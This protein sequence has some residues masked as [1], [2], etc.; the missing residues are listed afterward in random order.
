M[1]LFSDTVWHS[2]R[3][4]LLSAESSIERPGSVFCYIMSE[5]RLLRRFYAHVSRASL[6]GDEWFEMR[7][8]STSSRIFSR[9]GEVFG[10]RKVMPGTNLPHVVI[11]FPFSIS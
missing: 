8:S 5:L 9:P 4:T 3:A 10:D 7:S 6:T 11:G 2:D 1:S